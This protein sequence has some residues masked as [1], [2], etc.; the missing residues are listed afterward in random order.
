MIESTRET[1]MS[2]GSVEWTTPPNLYEAIC[3][4]V[5]GWKSCDVD[6][7][8]TADNAMCPNAWLAGV[9]VQLAYSLP[10]GTKEQRLAR[11][12]AIL[13]AQK[14]DCDTSVASVLFGDCAVGTTF[15]LNPPYGYELPIFMDMARRIGALGYTVVCLVPARTDTDWWWN[16]CASA[17]VLF[18]KGRIAFGGAKASAPFPSA[19]VVMGPSICVPGEQQYGWYEFNNWQLVRYRAMQS[20]ST[21][22]PTD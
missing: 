12:H 16:N 20:I 17:R 6:L 18:L 8:C 3:R 1:M 19:V 9:P 11:R 7:A 5:I 22:T 21:P 14:K 15:W 2:S 13:A 10:Q 4:R